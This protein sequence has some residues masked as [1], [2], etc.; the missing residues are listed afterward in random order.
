MNGA[1]AKPMSGTLPASARFTRRTASNTN[2]TAESTSTRGSRAIAASVAHG[3]MDHRPVALREL[4]PDAERLDDRRM[5]AKRMAAST[6]SR[7][8]G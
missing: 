5:S 1:P 8:S 4:E 7:A 3:P 2:G 6:P